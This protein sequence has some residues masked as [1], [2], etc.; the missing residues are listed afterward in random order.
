MILSFHTPLDA[1]L[2]ATEA[3]V[4]RSVRKASTCTSLN[5][6]RYDNGMHVCLPLR[7][8]GPGE[9]I[10]FIA[11]V[12]LWDCPQEALLHAEYPAE[13]LQHQMGSPCAPVW[14]VGPP[15]D[16]LVAPQVEGLG[17]CPA[18]PQ[19]PGIHVV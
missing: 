13:L 1:V 10:P 7:S 17:H 15:L 5:P 18:E 19:L 9:P 4:S 11:C 14:A 2:F 12:A 16:W 3:Q 6:W 8:Q